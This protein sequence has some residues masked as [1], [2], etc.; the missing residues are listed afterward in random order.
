M[1]HGALSVMT[2]G[3]TMRPWS[4]VDSLDSVTQVRTLMSNEVVHDQHWVIVK[5]IY[6]R[7]VC[8]ARVRIHRSSLIVFTVR[9]HCTE[10]LLI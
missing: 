9:Q 7:Y 8:G 2:S 3:I 5:V 4:S 6:Q 10:S 1:K